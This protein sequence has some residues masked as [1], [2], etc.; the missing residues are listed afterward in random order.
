MNREDFFAA[1]RKRDSGVFGTSLSQG[2]VD[3]CEAILDACY[4][5]TASLEQAAY[6]LATGYGETGG[7]MQAVRENL[8]YRA[9]AI[10]KHFGSHR[11]QGYTPE[12]LARNPQKLANTVYGGEWGRKNLGNTQPND[13]WDFRGWGIGQWTGRRNTEKAGRDV[14][15]DLVSDPTKLDDP[16]TNASLLV[17]WMVE[18]KAT[19]KRLGQYIN[20]GRKDYLAAR[21]VWGGVNASKYAQ[22]AERF[23]KALH[24]AGYA[25]STAPQKPPQPDMEQLPEFEGETSPWLALLKAILSIIGRKS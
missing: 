11:R 13:G 3:G 5:A 19:G 10:R 25:P 6:I 1:L 4:E 20:D 17:S 12:Q 9:S 21:A 15:L 18:G 14:G 2:Q 8:N 23:E 22:H 16:A 7:K 24:A